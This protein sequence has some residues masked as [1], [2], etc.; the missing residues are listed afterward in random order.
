MVPRIKK[1]RQRQ[2]RKVEGGKRKVVKEDDAYYYTSAWS[3]SMKRDDLVFWVYSV[4]IFK[5]GMNRIMR[6]P[7]STAQGSLIWALL[8]LSKQV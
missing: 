2:R 7:F 1:R 8:T 5:S 3:G 6:C 4:E